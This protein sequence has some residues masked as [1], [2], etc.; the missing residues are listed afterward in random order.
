MRLR[1]VLFTFLT[2]I[3]VVLL[4]ITSFSAVQN[5]R[6]YLQEQ[7]TAHAQDAAT[8]LG[9]VLTNAAAEQDQVSMEQM[10]GAVFD[11]GYYQRIE[12][13][14]VNGKSEIVK[15][16][17]AGV[18]DLPDWFVRM[19]DLPAPIAEAHVTSGWMQLGMVKVQSLPA[20]AYHELW[21]YLKK[22]CL[23]FVV[24]LIVAGLLMRWF[25]NRLVLSPL[26]ALETQAE[27][28]S[29]RRFSQIS[30]RP[31]TRELR[32]LVDAMNRMAGRL[33]LMF[34]DQVQLIE[35]LRSQVDED[36][37]TGLLNRSAFDERLRLT[38]SLSEEGARSGGLMLLQIKGLEEH[39]NRYGRESG[40]ELLCRIA[41]RLLEAVESVPGALL[42]RRSGTDFAVFLPGIAESYFADQVE[43]VYQMVSHS[44]AV[45][46]HEWQDRIH[47]GAVYL[48]P[49]QQVDL[50][51][52]FSEADVALREA[53][54]TGIG[55]WH[56][57]QSSGG[58]RSAGEWRHFIESAIARDEL[59]LYF[60]PVKA[61]SGAVVHNEVYVRLQDQ[62]R[63][64]A[65]GE[66]LPMVEQF[67]LMPSLDRQ[68]IE[69]LLMRMRKV[70][71]S[72]QYCINLSL[73]SL[74][75]E[76]FVLWLKET[77]SGNT[78]LSKRLVFEVPEYALRQHMDLILNRM[79]SLKGAGVSFSIDHFGV[80]GVPFA[81]LKTLPVTLVKVHRSFIQQVQSRRESQFYVMSMVQIAHSQDITIL[82]D[83]IETQEEW[84]YLQGLGIDGGLG[85]FLGRPEAAPV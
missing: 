34:S 81:Y 72:Q 40:D 20:E 23:Q 61:A 41:E 47:I 1:N 78:E 71:D 38:L 32:R 12:Y 62:D 73:A 80:G 52:A 22:V 51:G 28:W 50:G 63:V 44:E 7:L 82:A 59:L 17:G 35:R 53:Q 76:G 31:R 46:A 11:R 3:V 74:Q 54:Q 85:Y 42:S 56:V 48:F 10:I 57:G 75:D 33:E 83:G 4:I 2:G 16:T 6:A 49:Q 68:V 65:A 58:G 84:Q 77:L 15:Q 14:D 26:F 55:G 70:M 45:T 29:E 24:A 27:A 5:Y 21:S 66:F 30:I 60:Q 79:N 9:I 39:N 8:S 19:V 18:E 37:L 13:L 43:R 25:M 67:D 64:L 69:Q 36:G